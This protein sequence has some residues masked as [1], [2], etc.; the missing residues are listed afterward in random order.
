MSTH[1]PYYGIKTLLI[2]S[3]ICGA[4]VY[5]RVQGQEDE[6]ANSATKN[7]PWIQVPESNTSFLPIDLSDGTKCVALKAQEQ[8]AITC[9]WSTTQTP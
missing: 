2:I 1:N 4:I 8:V 7:A 3:L 9:N 6:R 5:L